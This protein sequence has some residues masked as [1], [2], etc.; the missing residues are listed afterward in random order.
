M[1]SVDQTHKWELLRYSPP[2]S[3][4]WFLKANILLQPKRLLHFVFDYLL[5]CHAFSMPS[6]MLS[7]ERYIF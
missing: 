6:Q 5:P 2:P 3:S 4:G 7:E 1:P